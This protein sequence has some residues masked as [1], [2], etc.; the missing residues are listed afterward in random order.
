MHRGVLENGHKH[1]PGQTSERVWHLALIRLDHCHPIR[2]GKYA[3]TCICVYSINIQHS[4]FNISEPAS[5]AHLPT[6]TVDDHAYVPHRTACPANEVRDARR[7]SDEDDNAE[8]SRPL[9]ATCNCMIARAIIHHVLTDLTHPCPPGTGRTA[10]VVALTPYT[11]PLHTCSTSTSTS[12]G[13]PQG[14]GARSS[15]SRVRDRRF[16]EQA[17]SLEDTSA[18]CCMAACLASRSLRSC[19]SAGGVEACCHWP[20]GPEDWYWYLVRP[21]PR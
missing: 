9:A 19:P 13:R 3:C 5:T 18:A 4:T 12:T 8:L 6:A 2:R 14:R 11:V 17:G 10:A 1:Y 7:A 15:S 16:G 20:G 21:V